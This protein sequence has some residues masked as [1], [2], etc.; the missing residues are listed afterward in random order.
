MPQLTAGASVLQAGNTGV[1]LADFVGRQLHRR[2]PRRHGRVTSPVSSIGAT[3][4]RPA[5]A[6]SSRRAPVRSTSPAATPTPSPAAYDRHH[7]RR[8][9]RRLDVTTLTA[10]FT[11]TD[12]PVTG[13]TKN[14]TAVE[15]QNTGL[16]V[17][18][19]FE[20]PN[21]LATLSDVKAELAVGGWGDGTP[22]VAGIQLTVQQ[23]GVDPAN[24]EPVFQVLGSHTYAEE[25]PPGLP[26]T[27]SVIITTLGGAQTT[28][29]SPPGGGVTVLDAQLTGSAGTDDHRYRGQLD[30]HRPAREPSSTPT[31]AP[32]SPTSPPALV[33]FWST[34]VTAP[35]L[36]PWPLATSP[37]SALP[38]VW[39]GSSPPPTP[40]TKR[41]PTPIPSR[42]WTPAARPPSSPVRPS[43][44]TPT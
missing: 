13:S 7:Q 39:P 14:F 19:T 29:T 6:P 2:Q 5:S 38:T 31:R 9:R 27:L 33:S 22:G 20:D 34:G 40:T 17:L 16:F 32:T 30:R 26:N 10:T 12:L 8:R 1:P 35:P 36:S 28:L 44:P 37:P 4:R 23:I 15:G 21:T 3:A 43:S 42:W 11:I 18:A 24:G 25:S 41:G